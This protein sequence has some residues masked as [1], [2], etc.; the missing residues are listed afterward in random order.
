ML[1]KS[2]T[3]IIFSILFAANAPS[4]AV[5]NGT[6]SDGGTYE[7][8]GLA[9]G[10]PGTQQPHAE[11]NNVCHVAVAGNTQVGN[12][13]AS[14]KGSISCGTKFAGGVWKKYCFAKV[15]CGNG[16]TRTCE[17]DENTGGEGGSDVWTV[18]QAQQLASTVVD[19]SNRVTTTRSPVPRCVSRL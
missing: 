4:E 13:C 15:T 9:P 3:I 19:A 7:N 18:V 1:R 14:G 10:S 6:P 17:V 2:L 12:Q 11:N 16:Q 8:C 5:D